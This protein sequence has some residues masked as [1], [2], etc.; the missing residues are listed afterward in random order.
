MV[1]QNGIMGPE[2][3]DLQKTSPFIATVLSLWH[4]V[5][6]VCAMSCVAVSVQ[7]LL[8]DHDGKVAAR[9]I[10]AEL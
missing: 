5:A 4:S 7:L 6:L 3:S 1:Q 10:K 2:V 8:T 9:A